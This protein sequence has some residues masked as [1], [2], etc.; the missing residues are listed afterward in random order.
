VKPAEPRVGV[1]ASRSRIRELLGSSG[2][3]RDAVVLSEILGPPKG[4]RVQEHSFQ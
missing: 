2:G 4:L 3:L 1:E